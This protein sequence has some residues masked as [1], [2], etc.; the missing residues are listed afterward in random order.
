MSS[1][2]SSESF[3]LYERLIEAKKGT[4]WTRTFPTH[5]LLSQREAA[6]KYQS[7]L[8]TGIFPGEDGDLKKMYQIRRVKDVDCNIRGE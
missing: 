5:R 6:K 7:Y 2:K 3:A 8:L 1:D 4:P